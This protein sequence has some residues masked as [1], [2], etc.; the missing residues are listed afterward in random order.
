MKYCKTRL[1]STLNAA[2]TAARLFELEVTLEVL[3][4]AAAAPALWL[5]TVVIAQIGRLKDVGQPELSAN[6]SDHAPADP[7]RKMLCNLCKHG[8]G[9]DQMIGGSEGQLGK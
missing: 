3:F 5:E 1:R 8:F 9:S 2:G 4:C 7:T 6:E